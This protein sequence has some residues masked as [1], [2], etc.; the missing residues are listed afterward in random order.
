[1]K[2]LD[3]EHF[4]CSPLCLIFFIFAVIMSKIHPTDHKSITIPMVL[5]V[6]L[7]RAPLVAGDGSIIYEVGNGAEA[8]GNRLC[9]WQSPLRLAVTSATGSSL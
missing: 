9:D 8:T 6:V 3:D 4:I 7:V 2:T 5:C 1:M